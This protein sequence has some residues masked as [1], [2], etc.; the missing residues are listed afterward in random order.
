MKS[1]RLP[2]CVLIVLALFYMLA[3]QA[4]AVDLSSW[5]LRN[6]R[7]ASAASGNGVDVAVGKYGFIMRSMI[8]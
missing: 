6:M 5:H 3:G 7:L 8:S 2:L 1:A 4:L